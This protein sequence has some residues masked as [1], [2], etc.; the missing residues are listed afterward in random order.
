[1]GINFT[2]SALCFQDEVL[3]EVG[4]VRGGGI[5]RGTDENASVFT[6]MIPCTPGWL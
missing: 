3:H 5:V 4:V 6:T 2:Y 1:M